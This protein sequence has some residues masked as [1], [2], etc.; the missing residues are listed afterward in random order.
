MK[1]NR[2]KQRELARE[3]LANQRKNGNSMEGNII[4]YFDGACEPKNPGGNMGIGA[5]IRRAG[6]EIFSTSQFVNEHFRNSNNVAEYMAFESILDYML[7]Q[8]WQGLT[9]T[10]YGDSNLVIEQ[11]FGTW[12]IKQG[13]YVEY[14][15]RCKKKIE[16]LKERNMKIAGIWIPR[17]QNKYADELSKAE[18]IK[19]NVQF[20]IQPL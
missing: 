16:M 19:N 20:Q 8:Y 2:K 14:A 9:I 6:E 17:A 15:Q 4:G 13:F 12:K 11:Q 5:C 3:Y 7:V 18:L 1:H 10:I